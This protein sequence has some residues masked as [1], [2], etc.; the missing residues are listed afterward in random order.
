MH[1][2][3]LS[4]DELI[5]RSLQGIATPA[6]EDALRT[7][8]NESLQNE[9]HYRSQARAWRIAALVEPASNLP[10]SVVLESVRPRRTQFPFQRA[11]ARRRSVHWVGWAAAVLV[12]LGGGLAVRWTLRPPTP[13]FAAQE[14]I[15][16]A[17]ERVTTRLNDGTVVRLAPNSRLRVQ[18]SA[19]RREVW[20]EGHAFF[21][22]SR[23]DERRFVVRTR[24][25]D[26]TVLGTRFDVRVDDDGMQVFVVEGRVAH[27]TGGHQVHVD[28]MELSRA[29]DGGVPE[30]EAVED[31]APLL[32]WL[33]D[34]LV[35]QSTPLS[36]IARELEQRYGV[37]VQLQDTALA[38]RTVTAWFTDESLEQVLLIVCRAADARCQNRDSTIS[39]NP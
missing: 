24:S 10:P 3:P 28:A 17:G 22:V 5:V 6:E 20:L 25:G 39:I 14:F 31:P 21:A 1:G 32:N 7:W 30:V 9:R 15:T 18:Q 26:A 37:D 29:T 27:Q 38:Q 4:I 8:R 19:L 13:G 33:G 12:L 34:F 11:G 2:G 16:G 36:E 23:D 35:F